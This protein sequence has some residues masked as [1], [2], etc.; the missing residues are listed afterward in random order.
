[1]GWNYLNI[2]GDQKLFKNLEKSPYVYFVHSYYLTS[3][4]KDLVA[5]TTNYG[6][7]FDVAITQGN[8]CATQFH[9]EKSGEV[10]LAILRNF[11]SL[12]K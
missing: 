2:K 3:E 9:P 7:E 10:G 4:N 6:M 8:V 5:A 1:M 11:I 12:I